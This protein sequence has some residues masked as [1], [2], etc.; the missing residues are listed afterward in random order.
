MT[1]YDYLVLYG[2]GGFLW[3]LLGKK[4][5]LAHNEESFPTEDE[6]GARAR[7]SGLRPRGPA[8][9]GNLFPRQRQWRM[10]YVECRFRVALLGSP[11][12]RNLNLSLTHFMTNAPSKPPAGDQHKATL[13]PGTCRPLNG[14]SDVAS[15]M[16][17]CDGSIVLD[18]Q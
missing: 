4:G 10:Q 8:G 7:S 13:L 17:T 18:T 3:F 12:V 1:V 11:L 9:S 16:Y 6:E 15:G 2:A 14:H 5:W